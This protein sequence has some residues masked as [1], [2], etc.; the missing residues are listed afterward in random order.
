MT[1]RDLFYEPPPSGL[2]R[3]IWRLLGFCLVAFFCWRVG[4]WLLVTVVRP[5]SIPWPWRALAYQVIGVSSLLAAVLFAHLVMLRWV[6]RLPWSEVGL[7][8]RQLS[9]RALGIGFALGLL[10]IGIPCGVLLAAHWLAVGPGN[11]PGESLAV[12]ALGS[13][14]FFLPQALAEEMTSR[15]YIFAVLR[16]AGGWQ[17]A[18]LATSLLFG[19]GHVANPNVRLL[20]IFVVVLAG[21]FLGGILVATG[22]LYAAWMAHFAWNWTMLGLFHARVSGVPVPVPGYSI[23]NSGPDWLTGGQWGPEGG[24]AAALGMTAGLAALWAWRSRNPGSVDGGAAD[25]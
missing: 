17:V 16:R 24:V 2:L 4:A 11:A 3:P 25:A 1:A 8:A 6:D 21:L 23:G 12:F 5:R 22:S 18:L 13:G 14:L 7:G 19:M 10:G 20:P 9:P 15:G